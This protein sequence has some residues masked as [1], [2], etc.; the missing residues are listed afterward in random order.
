MKTA[1]VVL[2]MHR[3]GTSSVAGTLSLLGAAA[4]KTLMAPADD[5][6]RGFWESDVVMALN[7]A[8]LAERGLSWSDWRARVGRSAAV[9][10][11]R[12][13]TV[14]ADEFGDAEQVVL[15]DPRLCRLFEEWRI[16]LTAADY[17]VRVV[18]PIRAPAEVARSL[19]ARNPM[20]WEHGLR[21]WLRHVLDA[22]RASRGL[23]RHT[24]MWTDFL[25]DWRGQISRMNQSLSVGLIAD[26]ESAAA[27]DTFLSD[28]LHRQRSHEPTPPLV[29]RAWRIL[30]DMATHGDHPD[31]L[32]ALDAVRVEFDHACTLFTD[33]SPALQAGS[34]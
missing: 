7:D 20:T 21:L 17:A 33:A 25:S 3:S 32:S 28:N 13:A 18:I 15:K 30:S 24:M 11:P 5:N 4:P 23:P 10:D 8:M 12:I 19:T 2:G 16:S 22:E 34:G 14:M 6:P 31:L 29:R 26:Q 9:A 27:V 1:L